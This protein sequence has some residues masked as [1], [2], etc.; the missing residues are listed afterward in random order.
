[1]NIRL[2]EPS[3]LVSNAMGRTP[4]SNGIV[5]TGSF[6]LTSMT[7]NC[8]PTIDPAT[9]NLPSGVTNVL[10]MPPLV[11]MVLIFCSDAV[12]M[13]STAPGCAMMAT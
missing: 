2:V 1:M 12:S 11:G 13:T 6:V 8:R 4:L 3:G 10:W 9:T 7:V 5:Q